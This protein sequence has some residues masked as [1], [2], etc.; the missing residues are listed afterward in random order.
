M[1]LKKAEGYDVIASYDSPIIYFSE[2]TVS[3]DM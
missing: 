3:S 1:N 2:N